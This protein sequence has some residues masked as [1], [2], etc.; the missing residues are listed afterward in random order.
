VNVPDSVRL[1]SWDVAK[2]GRKIGHVQAATRAA[3]MTEAIR[4]FA[5]LGVN[6][7]NLTLTASPPEH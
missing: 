7:T 3:A 1:P 4:Q 2:S 6:A 5:S